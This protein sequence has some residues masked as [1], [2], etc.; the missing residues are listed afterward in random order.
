MEGESIIGY[1]FSII[2]D[3]LMVMI[4]RLSVIRHFVSGIRHPASFLSAVNCHLSSVNCH[5]SSVNG[6]LNLH[7]LPQNLQRR[8]RYYKSTIEEPDQ[9]GNATY[10]NKDDNGWKKL[11][12]ENSIKDIMSKQPASDQ[13]QRNSG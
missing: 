3:E 6:Q 11:W 13:R 12:C 10:D 7:L 4:Y 9:D 2:G 8:F 1:Q 5:L